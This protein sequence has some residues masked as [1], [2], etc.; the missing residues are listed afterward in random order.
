MNLSKDIAA[1][2]LMVYEATK[3]IHLDSSP[4]VKFVCDKP[5]MEREL[6]RSCYSELD[7]RVNL[8]SLVLQSPS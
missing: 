4:G 7:W 5:R 8:V 1:K 2:V 6:L 3:K